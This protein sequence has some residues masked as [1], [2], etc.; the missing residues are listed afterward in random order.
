MDKKIKKHL[1]DHLCNQINWK[2]ASN[3]AGTHLGVKEEHPK[4]EE[5][6]RGK[7][8]EE[9]VKLFENYVSL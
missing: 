5:T 6:S 4:E 8:E 2:Q 3:T 7:E 1:V 9:E